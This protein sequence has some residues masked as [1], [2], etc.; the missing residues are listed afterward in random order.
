MIEEIMKRVEANDTGSMCLLAYLYF[1]G[2]MGEQQDRKKA[3]ELYAKA[4]DLGYSKAH[5]LL[6]DIY[7][8]FEGEI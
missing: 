6:G 5:I 1:K 7:Y 2:A 3:M 4:T 8:Y